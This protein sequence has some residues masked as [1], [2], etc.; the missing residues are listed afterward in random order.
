IRGWS[1]VSRGRLGGGLVGLDL[2]LRP[3]RGALL[4]RGL[5]R[6]L[7]LGGRLIG[8]RRRAHRGVGRCSAR[9]GATRS[10]LAR[11]RL[12][13]GGGIVGGRDRLVDLLLGISGAVAAGGLGG[14]FHECSFNK[15]GMYQS[16][17]ARERC[18]E[19]ARR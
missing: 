10:A 8:L 12:L 9:G 7:S 1:G 5:R 11:G 15:N 17:S 13:R 14:W 2:S 6:F 19:D 3:A 16:R 4:G 18:R